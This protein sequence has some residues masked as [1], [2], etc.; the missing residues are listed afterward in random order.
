[1]KSPAP[2]QLSPPARIARLAL[3]V[4]VLAAWIVVVLA[5]FPRDNEAASAPGGDRTTPAMR[6]SIPSAP[7]HV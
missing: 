6:H 5:M 2:S 4:A 3:L 1:M 7:E